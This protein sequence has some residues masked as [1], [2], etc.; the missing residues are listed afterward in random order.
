MDIRSPSSPSFSASI[1]H[2]FLKQHVSDGNFLGSSLFRTYCS[3]RIS[4]RMTPGR[5]PGLTAV[6]PT[7]WNASGSSFFG[8]V[9]A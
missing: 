3:D 7:V 9:K 6:P 5:V 1:P 8:I 4:V 2:P